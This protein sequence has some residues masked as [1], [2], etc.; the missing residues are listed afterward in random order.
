MAVQMDGENI[1]DARLDGSVWHFDETKHVEPSELPKDGVI[2]FVFQETKRDISS[3][4]VMAQEAVADVVRILK[5]ARSSVRLQVLI[6]QT[7]GTFF[8]VEDIRTIGAAFDPGKA[9]LEAYAV[10]LAHCAHLKEGHALLRETIGPTYETRFKAVAKALFTFNRENITGHYKLDMSNIGDRMVLKRLMEICSEQQRL[11]RSAGITT[12]NSQKGNNEFWRN[13]TLDGVSLIAGEVF[14]LRCNSY[15]LPDRGFVEFDVASLI[16][17]PSE[18]QEMPEEL[19]KEFQE[20]AKS[21][22]EQSLEAYQ[23]WLRWEVVKESHRYFSAEQVL[24][25]LQM[26]DELTAT[27]QGQARQDS[28]VILWERIVDE[29]NL[30]CVTSTFTDKDMQRLRKRI[31]TLNMFNPFAPD[32]PY[33]LDFTVPEERVI[34]AI[35]IKLSETEDGDN[36]VNE[37]YTEYVVKKGEEEKGPQEITWGDPEAITE[38]GLPDPKLSREYHYPKGWSHVDGLPDNLP[39]ACVWGGPIWEFEFHTTVKPNVIVRRRIAEDKLGWEF[40]E[41]FDQDP[42][43]DSLPNT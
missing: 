33:C 29:E 4:R 37:R 3:S 15:S 8:T 27:T 31:G 28:F 20:E 12:D 35:L 42:K 40:D 11:R 25:L 2:C 6:G 7:Y 10:L 19:F 17:P 21:K 16:R 13:E 34:A 43:P 38:E 30:E 23:T 41:N 36:L 5:E 24:A 22:M 1:K 18:A 9:Q 14:S 26:Q 39:D 32:G